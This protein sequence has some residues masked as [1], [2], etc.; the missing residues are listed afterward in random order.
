MRL[1]FVCPFQAQPIACMYHYLLDCWWNDYI[2]IF[3]LGPNH[4]TSTMNDE[5]IIITLNSDGDLMKQ[6]TRW[7]TKQMNNYNF[8][9]EYKK[10]RIGRKR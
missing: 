7:V 3:I 6:I 4:M 2:I 9:D 8:D 5:S 1:I 10:T